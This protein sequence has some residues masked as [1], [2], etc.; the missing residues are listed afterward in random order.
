MDVIGA[1]KKKVFEILVNIFR[2][3]S[4]NKLPLI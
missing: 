2:G 3:T 4:E 1:G